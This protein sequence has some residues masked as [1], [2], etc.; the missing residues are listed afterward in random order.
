[1]TFNKAQSLLRIDFKTLSPDDLHKHTISLLD[2]WR[3][4]KGDY[5]YNN[6]FFVCCPEVKAY[7]PRDKWLLKN[8]DN[9]LNEILRESET[10]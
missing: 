2:A 9:R 5:G 3:Y 7:I 4:A 10:T 6:D 8:I 1:M